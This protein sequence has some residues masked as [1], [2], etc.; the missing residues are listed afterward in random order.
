MRNTTFQ[1]HSTCS[2]SIRYKM[3][4]NGEYTPALVCDNHNVYID[5]LKR[6]DADMLH[7][8]MNIPI[9][10]WVDKKKKKK[11]TKINISKKQLR[12]QLMNKYV[13]AQIKRMYAK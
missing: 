2:C 13:S 8:E 10:T 3:F 7:K 1:K 5:W 12:N 11:K 4:S 6:E 9:K